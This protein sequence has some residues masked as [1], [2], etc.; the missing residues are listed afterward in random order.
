MLLL[1]ILIIFAI[2]GVV[3]LYWNNYY[4]DAEY[5]T[6]YNK[7]KYKNI[8]RAKNLYNFSEN[9]WPTWVI[10]GIIA[11]LILPICLFALV[12]NYSGSSAELASK[13]AEYDTI[14]YQVENKM[15]IT[16]NNIP[17]DAG[18]IIEFDSK[19]NPI[20]TGKIVVGYGQRELMKEVEAWNS[21]LANRNEHE[22]NLIWGVFYPKWSDKLEFIELEKVLE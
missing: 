15:Y 4:C 19:N 20:E 22:K 7:A 14:M 3:G 17:T 1:I 12:V 6:R 13:Q 18:Q 16:N 11:M 8:E 21:W 9:F 10:P 2:W 5:K